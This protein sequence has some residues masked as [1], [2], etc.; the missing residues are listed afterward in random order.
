[1]QK[2]QMFFLGHFGMPKIKELNRLEKSFADRRS[3]IRS[4]ESSPKRFNIPL[5]TMKLVEEQGLEMSQ[6]MPMTTMRS[7]ISNIEESINRL[8]RIP[9]TNLGKLK[10]VRRI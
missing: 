9:M 4:V 5:E 6:T 3:A 7:I 1:M 10:L 8:K 2:I